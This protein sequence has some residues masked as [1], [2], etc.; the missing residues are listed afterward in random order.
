VV[1]KDG[2]QIN[3]TGN[4]GIGALRNPKDKKAVLRLPVGKYLLFKT[5]PRSN[6]AS[7]PSALYLRSDNEEF[8]ELYLPGVPVEGIATGEPLPATVEAFVKDDCTE[9]SCFP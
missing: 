7:P 9:G 8:P 4:P 1:D 6:P 3:M 2:V 5:D